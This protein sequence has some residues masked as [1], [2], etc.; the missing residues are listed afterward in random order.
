MTASEEI[1]SL[2]RTLAQAASDVKAAS[3]TCIDV[4][5]QL[6]LVEV[7]L[8]LSASSQRQMRAIVNA[9]DEAAHKCGV[10]LKHREGM[11]SEMHWVLLDY[12]DLIVHI[13]HEDERDF[14]AL[15]KLWGDCPVIDVECS[16]SSAESQDSPL[17]S[18]AFSGS[19][20]Q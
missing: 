15:D 14:Y 18:Y 6:V 7:F 10:Q 17:L 16:F 19:E 12:G 4:S 8:V 1:V 11:S 9:V 20:F 3:G 13:F 5:E 2:A